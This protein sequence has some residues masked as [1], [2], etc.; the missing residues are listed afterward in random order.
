MRTAQNR[1]FTLSYPSNLPID[2]NKD[3]LAASIQIV[4]RSYK[5]PENSDATRFIRE[6]A[7]ASLGEN[8]P[9][10]MRRFLSWDEAREMSRAG[11]AVGS[12]THSHQ[13]LSQLKPEQQLKELSESR[14]ILSR[15]LGVE[16]D[17][18]AYPVGHKAS[19]TE[20]TLDIARK[21]GYRAAFSHYG[22]IN[23]QGSTSLFDI[24]RTKIVNQS[25]SRFRVQTD[26]CRP[27]GIYWP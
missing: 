27:T 17:V 24:R 8:P 15:Q 22:G 3:G 25:L 12:H 19:F 7:E 13:V 21:S 18:I 1:R 4:L 11:M 26:V 5:S 20:Q 9:K 14:A 16:A 6:L 2:L 10:T 23:M